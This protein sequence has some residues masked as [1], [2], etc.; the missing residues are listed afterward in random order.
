MSTSS[1]PPPPSSRDKAFNLTTTDAPTVERMIS[2]LYNR[3]IPIAAPTEETA[4]D[5]FQ[6]LAELNAFANSYEMTA[7]INDVVD[8]LLE[9]LKTSESWH[10]KLPQRL[11]LSEP[12][13]CDEATLY[14][15]L[16]VIE[17]VFATYTSHQF[18]QIL[19]EWYGCHVD[20][21]WM[22]EERNKE[23]LNRCKEFRVA[24]GGAVAREAKKGTVGKEACMSPLER[25][26]GYYH[27]H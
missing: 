12:W 20:V 21:A 22:R 6:N 24:L 27:E 14:P 11:K 8:S 9:A 4:E 26:G 5:V 16:E 25:E 23:V 2:W 15:S 13:T 19:I 3:R 7:L 18:R 10:I 1:S 17:Y